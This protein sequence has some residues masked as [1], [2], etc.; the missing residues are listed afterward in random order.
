MLSEM[1][2]GR[3]TCQGPKLLTSSLT[4]VVLPGCLDA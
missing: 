4:Q 2:R 3:I 1:T